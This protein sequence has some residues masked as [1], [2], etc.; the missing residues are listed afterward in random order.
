MHNFK[1]KMIDE[2]IKIQQPVLPLEL[3]LFAMFLQDI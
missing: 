2:K 1:N 3:E